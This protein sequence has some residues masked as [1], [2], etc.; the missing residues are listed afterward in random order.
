M[1]DVCVPERESQRS[2]GPRV[3]LFIGLS[4]SLVPRNC[5]LIRD[6]LPSHLTLLL[7]LQVLYIRKKKR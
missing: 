2:W 4:L 6:S 3:L 1:Q 5:W 7:L